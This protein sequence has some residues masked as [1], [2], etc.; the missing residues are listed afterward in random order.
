MPG[1]FLLGETMLL[2]LV[3]A[4]YDRGTERSRNHRQK[5]ERRLLGDVSARR[6]LPMLVAVEPVPEHASAEEMTFLVRAWK[7]AYAKAKALGW[8]D[9]SRMA[10][11]AGRQVTG[12]SAR[13]E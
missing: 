13:S 3:R 11:P 9:W 4:E 8:L 10:D 2:V 12:A 5:A 6:L 1:R 7:A